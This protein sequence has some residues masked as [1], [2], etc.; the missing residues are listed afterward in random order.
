[1]HPDWNSVK[2]GH[3]TCTDTG[4]KVWGFSWPQSYSYKMLSDGDSHSVGTQQI[5]Y[6]LHPA[7]SISHYILLAR[8]SGSCNSHH[9]PTWNGLSP[10]TLQ[11][12]SGSSFW[13]QPKCHI[14]P[15]DSTCPPPFQNFFSSHYLPIMLTSVVY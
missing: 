5:L 11:V 7:F 6:P 4:D 2:A 14:L 10:S 9:F 13:V 8:N 12:K 3:W 15:Q 1:M